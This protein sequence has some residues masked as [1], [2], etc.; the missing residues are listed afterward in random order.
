M[1]II[2]YL[3]S[4]GYDEHSIYGREGKKFVRAYC[5]D[6]NYDND[7][8]R[9]VWIHIDGD[10]KG[11]WGCWRCEKYGKEINASFEI[12]AAMEGREIAVE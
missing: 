6:C 3:K 4:I 10:K 9:Q 11:Q 7:I 5:P 1:E 8:T 12:S 2:E